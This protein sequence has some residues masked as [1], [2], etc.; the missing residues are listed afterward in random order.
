MCFLVFIEN[1][2]FDSD[3]TAIRKEFQKTEERIKNELEANKLPTT[4]DYLRKQNEEAKRE[5]NFTYRP[6]FLNLRSSIPAKTDHI[7]SATRWLKRAGYSGM[8]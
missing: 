2:F 5:R 3:Q 8:A 7:Y 4:E 1:L 6:Q